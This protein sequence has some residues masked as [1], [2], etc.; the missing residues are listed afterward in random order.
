MKY[1]ITTALI[2]S[3]L[4]VHANEDK[5]ECTENLFNKSS[6]AEVSPTAQA[7]LNQSSDFLAGMQVLCDAARSQV[8]TEFSQYLNYKKNYEDAL[9]WLQSLPLNQR[10]AV[11]NN[12]V[13]AAKEA[14][15]TLGEK[16]RIGPIVYKAQLTF[17]NCTIP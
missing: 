3:S 5:N 8:S 15:V 11:A 13:S 14:W 16:N 9:A 7:C 4:L 12:K 6:W 1:I 10:G 17:T 2:F